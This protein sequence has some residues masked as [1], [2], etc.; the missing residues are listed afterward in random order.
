MTNLTWVLHGGLNS[1]AEADLRARGYAEH[2]G[3]FSTGKGALVA[4][5][6]RPVDIRA[7]TNVLRV[8][9]RELDGVVL[10]FAS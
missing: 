10:G 3:L 4:S 2:F 9:G 5:D 8:I 7:I 6:I 1:D